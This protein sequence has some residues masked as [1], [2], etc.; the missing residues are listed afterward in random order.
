M[1]EQLVN[2]LLELDPED[3]PMIRELV[4]RK[5]RDGLIALLSA[6][7]ASCMDPEYFVQVLENKDI[8]S[9]LATSRRALKIRELMAKI[10][11]L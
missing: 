9:A 4:V 7:A 8:N 1:N 5:K 3:A 2:E 6:R 11:Q 10:I